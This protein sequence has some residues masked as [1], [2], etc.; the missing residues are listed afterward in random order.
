MQKL[1][2]TQT[3]TY[4][5]SC[6]HIHG[7]KARLTGCS[8]QYVEPV[9]HQW[10]PASDTEINQERLERMPKMEPELRLNY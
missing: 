7:Q 5:E 8:N 9:C 2:N 10:H 1:E 6:C 4:L 3:K